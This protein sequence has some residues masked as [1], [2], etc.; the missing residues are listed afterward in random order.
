MMIGFHHAT[1]V[2]PRSYECKDSLR[3]QQSALEALQQATEAFAVSML[4]LKG[5]KLVTEFP[6]E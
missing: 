4:C 6:Y 1:Q 2:M 5:E 3:F